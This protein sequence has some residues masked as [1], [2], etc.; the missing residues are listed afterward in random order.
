MAAALIPGAAVFATPESSTGC[1][2][3]HTEV[4]FR[5]MI[6]SASVVVIGRVVAID[7]EN[8]DDEQE[9]HIRPEAFLKG[10]STGGDLRFR[11]SGMAMP[12]EYAEFQEGD[13]LLLVAQGRTE[14]FGWPPPLGAYRLEDGHAFNLNPADDRRSTEVELVSRIRGI[15]G[16][17]AVPADSTQEGASIDW[18]GTVLPVGAALLVIFGISLALMRLWHRID[19]S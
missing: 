10:P 9:A 14:P 15:T 17:Y 11:R 18:R 8:R 13:R 1:D 2:S 4:T 19:P 6:D 7:G 3:P 5:T 12:C 16:Q